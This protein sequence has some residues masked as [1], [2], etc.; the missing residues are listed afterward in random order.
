MIGCQMMYRI[1]EALIEAKGNSEPFGGINFIVAEDF[2]QLLPIEETRLYA[3]VNTSDVP[4]LDW[5]E[6]PTFG[7]ALG[8]LGLRK[9]C[10]GPKAKSWAW[11]GLALAQAG[12]LTYIQFHSF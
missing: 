1:S 5:P 12:L 10:T 4:A 7:L 2:V 11:L 8:G 6:S 3:S 9:L